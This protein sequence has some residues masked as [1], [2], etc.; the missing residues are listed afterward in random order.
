M[1][2]IIIIIIFVNITYIADETFKECDQWLNGPLTQKSDK[3]N[4]DS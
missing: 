1:I 2:I 4:I 3:L